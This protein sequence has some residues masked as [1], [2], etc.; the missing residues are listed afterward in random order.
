M[1]KYSKIN[2]LLQKATRE[3]PFDTYYEWD[4]YDK[5]YDFPVYRLHVGSKIFVWKLPIINQLE[6]AEKSKHEEILNEYL[7]EAV[8]LQGKYNDPEA[9]KERLSNPSRKKWNGK[10]FSVKAVNNEGNY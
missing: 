6:D 5:I 3:E 9:I 7:M 4:S 2:D 8:W 1:N 10:R